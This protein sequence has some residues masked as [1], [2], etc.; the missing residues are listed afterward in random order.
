L[1]Q[2]LDDAADLVIDHAFL[3][4][5]YDTLL[6]RGASAS[7]FK[8]T[9]TL[10]W[11]GN[12]TRFFTNLFRVSGSALLQQENTAKTIDV[13]VKMYTPPELDEA[14]ILAIKDETSA[15]GDISELAMNKGVAERENEEGVLLLSSRPTNIVRFFG[16]CV[17]PPHL[18]LVFELCEGGPLSEWIARSSP[19]PTLTTRLKV[20]LD[21]ALAVHFLHDNGFIHRDLKSDNF[22]LKNGTAL[23]T[24]FGTCVDV[25]RASEQTFYL[26][27]R[28]AMQL[29]HAIMRANTVGTIDTMAP[30]LLV[31]NTREMEGRLYSSASDV[32]ALGIV[33]AS[34]IVFRP[35]FP[36]LREW[37]VREKVLKGERPFDANDQIFEGVRALGGWLHR[38]FKA[39]PIDRPSALEL[40]EILEA[41]QAIRQ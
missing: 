11:G 27:G 38:A 2:L 30:E 24:D 34:I 9:L 17:M 29:R 37:N 6:G 36:G 26:G 8:G 7:V 13:A 21:C 14:A 31:E 32:Y 28:G 18:S 40:V 19:P 39:N 22:L 23:L 12:R 5:D 4:I 1:Q 41:A 35:P 10:L 16:M 33:V 15:W 20:A 3:S 25:E